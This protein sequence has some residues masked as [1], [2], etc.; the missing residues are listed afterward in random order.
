MHWSNLAIPINFSK[1]ISSFGYIIG[2]VCGIGIPNHFCIGLPETKIKIV[3][4]SPKITLQSLTSL[5][6]LFEFGIDIKMK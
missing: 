4:I 1:G 3:L 2:I 5:N 6:A